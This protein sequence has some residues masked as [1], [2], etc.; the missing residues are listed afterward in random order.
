M[1]S[2]FF[3]FCKL[4]I[5]DWRWWGNILAGGTTTIR[6]ENTDNVLF[7]TA[8]YDYARV[9]MRNNTAHNG[10]VDIFNNQVF[11]HDDR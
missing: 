6:G 5:S 11:I 8:L 4:Q 10:P 7:I 1:E 9:Q 3:A 2:F